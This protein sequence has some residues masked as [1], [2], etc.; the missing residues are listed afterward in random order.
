MTRDEI[1]K[2]YANGADLSGANLPEFQIPQEGEMIVWK[3][4]S[5]GLLAKMCASRPVRS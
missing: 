5:A 1:L 2:A 3:K 4:L